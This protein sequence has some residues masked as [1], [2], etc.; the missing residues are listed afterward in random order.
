MLGRLPSTLGHHEFLLSPGS[1]VSDHHNV[2]GLLNVLHKADGL[3]HR[4][5]LHHELGDPGGHA[6]LHARHLLP[7]LHQGP[8]I[9]DVAVANPRLQ[10]GTGPS[11]QHFT[12]KSQVFVEQRRNT[13]RGACILIAKKFSA[14]ISAAYD[15][16]PL[17]T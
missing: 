6:I 8:R 7:R 1:Q 13:K 11:Q 16:D 2:Q 14:Q 17:R 15:C 4:G 5:R 12:S 3:L 9:D 10:A